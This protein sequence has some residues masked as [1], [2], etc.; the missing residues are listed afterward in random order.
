LQLGSRRVVLRA[1]R[2]NAEQQEQR[3]EEKAESGTGFH[4]RDIRKQTI[5]RNTSQR[6]DGT[7]Q[8]WLASAA[9]LPQKAS[10]AAKDYPLASA[11]SAADSTSIP[12]HVWAFDLG[13]RTPNK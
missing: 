5:R 9:I 7:A 3:D 6:N 12:N 13:K 1:R 2:G 4:A 10:M 8:L 11:P